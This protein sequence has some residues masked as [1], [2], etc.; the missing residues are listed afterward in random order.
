MN[1]SAVSINFTGTA[2]IAGIGGQ[3]VSGG[4]AVIGA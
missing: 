4:A 1:L 2:V 3:G